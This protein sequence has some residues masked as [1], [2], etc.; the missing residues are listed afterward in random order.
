VF[1]LASK[2]GSMTTLTRAPSLL[3]KS[4]VLVLAA[5]M[6]SALFSVAQAQAA[7][8]PELIKACVNKQTK[9]VRISVY[10]S[11]S[12]CGSESFRTWNQIG[13]K[14]DP[15]APGLPG[16]DGVSGYEV[17]TGDFVFTV[18][19]EFGT[20]TV[21][22]PTGKVPVGGGVKFADVTD[23]GVASFL[24]DYPTNT[25]WAV[26]WYHGNQAVE[27]DFTAYAVCASMS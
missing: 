20:A 25:G 26:D 8:P 16:A 10:A 24:S 22:C 13:P 4:L 15:G 17:V 3:R 14:G 23:H 18:S 12:Y 6:A 1:R 19:V 27:V 5:A 9:L 2:E 21:D 7:A 11:K